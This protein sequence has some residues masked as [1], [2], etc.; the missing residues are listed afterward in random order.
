MLSVAQMV[1]MSRLLDESLELDPAARRNWLEALP[2]EHQDLLPSL[3]GALLQEGDGTLYFQQ[4]EVG[5]RIPDNAVG[6]N[7]QPGG[8]IGPYLLVRALGAGGMAEVWLAQRA[9]GAFKREVALKL[10][11]LSRLREDLP[12]RFARERDILASLEHPNIARLYDAGVSVEGRPYLAMECVHGE[13]LIAWCNA[14]CLGIRER[15]ELFVQ[16]L[17]AVQYAH[18]QRVI[19]RDIKPSNI[20]VTDSGQVR[21]LDFG[22]AK[23]LAQE[24]ERT[25]LT[26]LYGR[27]LTPEYASPELARGDAVGAAADVYSLGVVLYELLC[28]RRPYRLEAAVSSAALLEQVIAAAQVARPSAH[29][30]AAAGADRGTTQKKLAR[31]LRGDLDAIVLKALVKE[32][33]DRYTSAAALGD[34]LKRYLGGE[35]VHA[36]PAHLAYRATKFALRHRTGLATAVAV[37]VLVAAA[38]G[39]ELI[40][41]SGHVAATRVDSPVPGAAAAL[42]DRSLAVLPFLDMSEKH[43]QEYFSDGLSEE[44]ID[45][46]SRSRDLRV[47]SRTS[48][49]YFKGRPATIGEIAR[50]LNVSHVLEGSVRKNGKAL[51][52]TVQLIRTSDGSHLWSR[53]YDR[54]L[55]D[56][57]RVQ[58]EIAG[59]VALALKAALASPVPAPQDEA[60]SQAY[61]LVLEGEFYLRRHNEG[62]PERATEL[63]RR[64]VQMD[65]GN[66]RARLDLAGALIHMGHYNVIPPKL[67]ALEALEAARGA[68]TIDPGSARAHR[69]IAAIERDFNWNWAGAMAELEQ[70]VSVATDVNER[71]SS[72]IAIQYLKA[73][74]SGVY[75]KE[76]EDLL[77]EVLAVDPLDVGT[78]ATLAAVLQANG[79]LEEAVSVSTRLL[80][81]SPNQM[82]A[83]AKLG[84]QLMHLSR[85]ADA[86]SFANRESSEYW[87][88]RTL[89]CIHWTMGQRLESDRE[90]AEFA[91]LAQ[92]AYDDYVVGAIH[93]FRG[94]SDKAFERLESAYQQHSTALQQLNIDP[95]LKN[96]RSD[97]R[98][99][100]LQVRMNLAS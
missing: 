14:H 77:R 91:K 96:L 3:R 74:K 87:R 40:W 81:I 25:D 66:L 76:Y 41:R 8:R 88:L 71:R 97:P 5:G 100:G 64:A 4:H 44:L 29:L 62:D 1:R 24:E 21:L 12:S 59:T 63:Y 84:M 68:L 61:N 48:S 82:S 10:P 92:D 20:L 93:A 89:T 79:R 37:I 57:F 38:I 83:N 45:R 32:P 58:D 86:V 9:D 46:L 94:E 85:Y 35:A 53:T 39:Y 75:S 73:L 54:N 43:D 22:V 18:G 31:R 98:F 99:H 67:A 6:S 28:G 47:I 23:L 52:I 80:E 55:V 2:P 13:P 30:G 95:M 19:H 69:L 72:R 90:L 33:E 17:D 42:D 15:L 65:P 11:M 27:A 36:R 56:I 70:S 60:G 78:M 34:D 26:Q 49:F 51:R 16:V 50:T 7:L